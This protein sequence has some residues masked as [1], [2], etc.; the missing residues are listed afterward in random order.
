ML[1]EKK[2]K[3][4]T[5]YEKEQLANFIRKLA[6]LK[7]FQIHIKGKDIKDVVSEIDLEM[8]HCHDSNIDILY[9]KSPLFVYPIAIRM[10][11]MS[12]TWKR[13]NDSEFAEVVVS[14][15]TVNRVRRKRPLRRLAIKTNATT[16]V[17]DLPA[18]S[19][20]RIRKTLNY[21]LNHHILWMAKIDNYIST[22]KRTIAVEEFG[23]GI[24][25]GVNV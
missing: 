15:E 4:L 11:D 23:T 17:E 9:Q 25:G 19:F 13:Q 8:D 2:N 12:H 14:F 24:K 22:K 1:F 20:S 3:L 18:V 10:T 5:N 6:E 7:D 16:R 21:I